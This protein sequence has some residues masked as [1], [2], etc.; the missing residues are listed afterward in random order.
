MSES[1]VFDITVRC[2][3][4]MSCVSC[5][6]FSLLFLAFDSVWHIK[7]ATHQL[8]DARKYS[9]SYRSYY[10]EQIAGLTAG[11]S[12]I[13]LC[14]CFM[15][16]YSACFITQYHLLPNERNN[17]KLWKRCALPSTLTAG[18]RPSKWR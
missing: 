15:H 11:Q 12:T 14:K 2:S 3:S 10:N 13:V 17:G 18:S 8:L 16:F 5:L 6:L 1:F 4:T 7:L 9:L